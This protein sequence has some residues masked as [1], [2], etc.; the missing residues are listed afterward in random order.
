MHPPC[1][2]CGMPWECSTDDGEERGTY[3]ID[4]IGKDEASLKVVVDHD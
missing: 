3:T 4:S 1:P 2:L